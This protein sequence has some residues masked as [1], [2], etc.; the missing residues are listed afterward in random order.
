[1]INGFIAQTSEGGKLPPITD[2]FYNRAGAA[3]VVGGVYR[4]DTGATADASTTT[5]EKGLEHLLLPITASLGNAQYVVALEA[6][7]DDAQVRAAYGQG[8]LVS[9][10]VDGNSVNIAKGDPLKPVNGATDLVKATAQDKYIALA[11]EAATTDNATIKAIFFT[12][13]QVI[14]GGS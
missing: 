6:V 5:V 8:V 14:S 10:R 12:H 7:A 9:L 11:L 1:M 3:T 4:L 13:P 2:H